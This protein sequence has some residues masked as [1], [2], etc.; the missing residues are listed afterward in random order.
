MISNQEKIFRT[1]SPSYAERL[2]SLIRGGL[3]EYYNQ[4]ITTEILESLTQKLIDDLEKLMN[5]DI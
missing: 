1:F 3:S 2:L 5:S 4:T